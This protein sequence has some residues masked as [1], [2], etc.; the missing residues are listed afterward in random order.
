MIL[1][2]ENEYEKTKKIRKTQRMKNNEKT[3]CFLQCLDFANFCPK[4]GKRYQNQTQKRK[5]K[6]EEKHEK[7]KAN[8][9]KSGFLPNL[10]QF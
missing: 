1:R 8:R 2:V 10:T 5:K 9:K 6:S 7:M 3:R 4:T